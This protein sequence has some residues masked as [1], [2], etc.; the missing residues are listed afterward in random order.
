VSAGPRRC[1]LHVGL[2]K[3]GTS[4]LQSVVWASREQLEAQGLRLLMDRPADHFHATLALRGMLSEQM[5]PQEAF[6]ALDRLAASAADGS[7]VLLTH[8]SLAPATVEQVA[9][10]VGLVPGFEVHVVVTARDLARQITSGWQQRIQ[11]RQVHAYDEFVEAVVQRRPMADDF[12]RNQDLVD[13]AR[14]WSSAVPAERVHV[15]TVPPPGSAPGLLLDRFCAVLGVDPGRLSMTAVQ[16]NESLGMV[17][18][19]LLRR[20]NVALGDR[21]P[22]ARAG[23]ARVGKG[24]LARR[25]LAP[26][27]GEPPRLPPEV[28]R[29]CVSRSMEVVQQLGT[30][31]YHIVGDLK[32]LIPTPGGGGTARPAGTAE[33]VSDA[34]LLRS[35]VEAMADVLE[36]RSEDVQRLDSL[37]ERVR[38]QSERIASLTAATAGTE[39]ASRLP[40]W[41]RARSQ[42]GRAVRRL[43]RR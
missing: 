12:W 11:E 27:N 39:P 13:V 5:D 21:L 15:V 17:Q 32:E 35:A 23:Y 4:Y 19:E 2:P 20:V 43:R 31:G 24:F 37:R 38:A 42:A 30:A 9:Q 8:E 41:R 36:I 29:W 28:E 34:A 1:Y 33:P 14:R 40:A 26:Q 18:A 6:S 16:S 10:M 3:T 7:D 22:H 25:V